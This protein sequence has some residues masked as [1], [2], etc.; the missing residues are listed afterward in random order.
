MNSTIPV[1]PEGFVQ[2]ILKDDLVMPFQLESSALRGRLV[3]LG[4]VLDDILGAHDYPEAVSSQVAYTVALTALLASM[5]KYEG[6]FTLQA[7]GEGALSMLVSDVTS[8]GQIRGCA[9]FDEE[10]LAVV[11]GVNMRALMDKGYIAFTVDQGADTERYQGIVELKGDTLIESIQHYFTQ[12]EQIATGIVL[13][14]GKRAGKWRAQGIML[15]Q[16][17]EEGGHTVPVGNA[18]EDD[19]RRAMIL[20]Q[21]AKEDEMLD[22]DLTPHA[23]LTRLFHEEGVR[24]YGAR[25][26]H[27][28]CRCSEEKIIDM[29]KMMGEED[30]RDMIVDG[31]ITMTCEFCGHHYHF[32][33]DQIASKLPK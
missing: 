4:S 22:E 33:P 5:L 21:S 6:I 15:Q 1:D 32:A 14:I 17:P 28:G 2:E 26:L 31:S 11:Q 29:M 19:W 13:H 16:M 7:Q 20:M 10:K 23:M 8:G 27:K 12:S 18:E 3:R 24:V 30:I 9:T 25:P